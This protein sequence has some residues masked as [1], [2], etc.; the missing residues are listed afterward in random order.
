MVPGQEVESPESL[1]SLTPS[2]V[3]SLSLYSSESAGKNFPIETL[4]GLEEERLKNPFCCCF[5]MWA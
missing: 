2:E 4:Q 5:G 1:E 3:S